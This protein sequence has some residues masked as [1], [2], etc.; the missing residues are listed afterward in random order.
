MQ[1]MPFASLQWLMCAA[2]VAT[3][4]VI[5]IGLKCASRLW[6]ISAEMER[7]LMHIGNGLCCLSLPWL[8]TRWLPVVCLLSIVIFSP[9]ILRTVPWAARVFG[10]AMHVSRRSIGAPLFGISFLL[11]FLLAH[12]HRMLYL[13]A[14]LVLVIPDALAAMV[15]QT[16]PYYPFRILG[17]QKTLS[18]SLTFFIT[19]WFCLLCVIML[20]SDRWDLTLWLSGLVAAMVTVIEAISGFGM[21]NLLIPLTVLGLLSWLLPL[22]GVLI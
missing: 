6:S 12:T 3:F 18:G 4:T 17:G 13:A 7:K 16:Y 15:G 20:M 21:D 14:A 22:N 5:V 9:W 19:A 1:V 2:V 8:F 11:L 10:R